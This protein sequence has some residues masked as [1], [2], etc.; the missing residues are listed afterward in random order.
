MNLMK[1]FFL[2][3][4]TTTWTSGFCTLSLCDLGDLLYAHLQTQLSDSEVHTIVREAVDHELE[5]VTDALPVRLIGMNADL[6]C[7][8][9]LKIVF[10]SLRSIQSC[11]VINQMALFFAAA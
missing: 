3:K 6:M 11:Q 5:F 8:E 4:K 2:C 10:H 1:N 9:S 7:S